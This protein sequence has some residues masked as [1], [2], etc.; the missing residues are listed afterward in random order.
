MDSEA[1]K[2]AAGGTRFG[3]ALSALTAL[4]LAVPLAAAETHVVRG[5]DEL[6]WVPTLEQGLAMAEAT[7][8]PLFLMG[9][10]LVR[11]DKTNGKVVE[12]VKL[13]DDG[14]YDAVAIFGNDAYLLGQDYDNETVVVHVTLP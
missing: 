4:V 1:S 14:W 2:L 10:S 8:R 6:F 9:Y 5:A 12:T 11:L 3:A 7:G 13:P